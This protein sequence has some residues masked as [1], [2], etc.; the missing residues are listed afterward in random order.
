MSLDVRIR[1]GKMEDLPQL[2]RLWRELIG[3]DES[4]GGQDFRLAAGAPEQWERHLRSYVGKRRRAA[5]VAEVEGAM[6][7]FLLASLERPPGIFMEREYGHVAAV[8]VQEPYRGKGVGHALVAGGLG[9][10]GERRVSRV[11]V[12]TDSKNALGVEFWKRLGFQ[13]AVL[14]MDKLL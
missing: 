11:R 8:Y 9:W 2:V 14:A 6:V 5:F 3:F 7:G 4:L 10:F 12:A 1:S 13:T